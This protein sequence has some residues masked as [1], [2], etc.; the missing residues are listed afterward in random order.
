MTVEA[1]FVVPLSFFAVVV[2]LNLF[3]FL[4]VQMRVQKELSSIGGEVMALGTLFDK[5]KT[6]LQ[7]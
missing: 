3:L 6:D 5:A 2:F 7:Y 1:A 4:Q